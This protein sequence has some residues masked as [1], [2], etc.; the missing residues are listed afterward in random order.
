MAGIAQQQVAFVP[1]N[2]EAGKARQGGDPTKGGT[3]AE[4]GIGL[5]FFVC[6]QQGAAGVGE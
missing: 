2:Q 1:A 4:K 5:A 3:H 6:S